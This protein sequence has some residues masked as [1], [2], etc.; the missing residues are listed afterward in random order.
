MPPYEARKELLWSP[1][2]RL[3]TNALT[4]ALR[5]H[6]NKVTLGFTTLD[7]KTKKNLNPEQ[8]NYLTLC[9]KW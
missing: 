5:V 3:G 6:G 8:A 2:K 1:K 7:P 4:Y 9:E